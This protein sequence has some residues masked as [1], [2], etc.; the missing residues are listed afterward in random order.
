MPKLTDPIPGMDPQ[1]SLNLRAI[2]KEQADE[3]ADAAVKRFVK[4]GCPVACD[5]MRAVQRAVFGATE[6]NI[7]GLDDRMRGVERSLGY[8]ARALWIAI[9]AFIVAL[10]GVL[11][12]G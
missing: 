9:G 4:N 11:F 7:I 10:A 12:K 2:M 8:A 6:D 1:T 3:S 5:D